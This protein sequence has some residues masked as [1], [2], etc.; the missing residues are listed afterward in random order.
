MATILCEANRY[1]RGVRM[2]YNMRVST[3]PF[4]DCLQDDKSEDRQSIHVHDQSLVA[5]FQVEYLPDR[6]LGFDIFRLLEE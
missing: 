2:L 6:F 5:T 1:I 4:N 3:I